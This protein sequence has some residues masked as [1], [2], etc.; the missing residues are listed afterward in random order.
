MGVG[1]RN[2]CRRIVVNSGTRIQRGQTSTEFI[3][4]APVILL[5]CLGLVQFGLLYR[6]KS[7][8]NYATLMA[9]RAGAVENGR[10]D[11]MLT[12]L[13]HG[14]APLFADQAAIS[15]RPKAILIAQTEV[16]NPAITGLTIVN[17]TDSAFTDFSRTNYYAG[18]TVREIPNDT[19]MY[20]DSSPGKASQL[21]IQDANLL[22]ITVQY[23]FDLRVPFI[24]RV[25]YAM[26]GAENDVNSLNPGEHRNR[27][28]A[29]SAVTGGYR[30]PLQSEAMVRMQS[31]FR[32]G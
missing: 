16:R 4:M 32:G 21:S 2:K 27:C 13:A 10:K 12:G 24:N 19:L 1:M 6:A 22:K 5:L 3:I 23:C 29:L 7:L 30:V 17:P 8:L 18:K 14:L 28:R 26:A 20:R 11:A 9:A 15:A 31:P 25:I